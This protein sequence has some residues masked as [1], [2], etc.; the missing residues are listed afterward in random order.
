MRHRQHGRFVRK[1]QRTCPEVARALGIHPFI[2]RIRSPLTAGYDVKGRFVSSRC[3]GRVSNWSPR[4]KGL[5]R[6]ALFEGSAPHPE[7][8]SE[9]APGSD[10][11]G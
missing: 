1:L 10:G 6:I 7:L 11:F 4:H 2:W 3:H 5:C 9:G 8:S